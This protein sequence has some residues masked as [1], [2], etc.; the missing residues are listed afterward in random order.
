[1][2]ILFESPDRYHNDLRPLFIRILA[3]ECFFS[4]LYLAF[5]GESQLIWQTGVFHFAD[6][7]NA[8]CSVYNH[9]YLC[10]RYRFLAS[11]CIKLSMNAADSKGFYYVSEVEQAYPFEC[12][13]VPVIL[14]GI[15]YVILPKAIVSG[16]CLAEL[17]IE[18]SKEIHQL[19]Y[20]SHLLCTVVIKT[21]EITVD[22]VAENIA[23]VSIVCKFCML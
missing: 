14:F 19:E 5:L 23:K 1:M 20:A 7:D 11:P 6:I 8:V 15:I 22:E 4:M 16:A 12:Q 17:V 9:V 3:K 10:C 18:Q 2:S 21:N 13:S